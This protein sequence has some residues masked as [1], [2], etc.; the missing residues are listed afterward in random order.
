MLAI[1]G[2]SGCGK[3]LLLRALAGRPLDPKHF[4]ASGKISLNDGAFFR[5]SAWH[6]RI[7]FV[8]RSDEL[9][10]KLTVRETV[11]F[12]G[13]LKA[14]PGGFDEA[15]ILEYW[16]LERI[17]DRLVDQVDNE[18]FSIGNRK[19]VAIAVHTVHG[20]E[21]LF[22]DEPSAGLDPRR[23]EQLM[24]D[25]FAYAQSRQV[26]IVLTL[27]PYSSSIFRFFSRILLLCH[28]QTVFFGPI[29]DAFW[30]FERAL[31]RALPVNQ[32]PAEFLTQMITIEIDPAIEDSHAALDELR[33]ELRGK[34][35]VWKDLFISP[36]PSDYPGW[37]PSSSSNH[38]WPN[39][40]W[41][42]LKILLRREFIE[43]SR[44]YPPVIYI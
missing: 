29:Q 26:A 13:L 37:I 8:Q 7:G 38:S 36:A 11:R 40:R 4:K 22:L 9:Y 21:V 44:D 18:M 41:S 3:T 19:R 6:R 24:A 42:E 27:N 2:G 12:A 33:E 30:Y 28:G 23:E 32:S 14:G 10:P 5:S 1:M 25:L 16:Q 17:A 31:G 43:Q 35:L 34:W 20:P 39:S 15:E